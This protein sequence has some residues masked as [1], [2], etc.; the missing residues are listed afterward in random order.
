MED[1]FLDLSKMDDAS[2]KVLK[3]STEDMM[4]NGTKYMIDKSK[5]VKNI[6]EMSSD[7]GMICGGIGLIVAGFALGVVDYFKFK[8]SSK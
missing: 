7:F 1:K 8:K 5:T 3:E 4:N 2:F 6:M